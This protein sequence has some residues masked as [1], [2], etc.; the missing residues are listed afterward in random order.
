MTLTYVWKLN[1]ATV[2]TTAASSSLT[3]TL[4][5]ST[6]SAANGDVLSVEVTPNDGT[7]NGTMVSATATVDIPMVSPIPDNTF[8]VGG[9]PG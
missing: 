2:K 3:D 8:E 5:L 4:D 7:A 9:E 6:T 1:G